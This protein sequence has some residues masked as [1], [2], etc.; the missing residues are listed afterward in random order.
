MDGTY[1]IPALRRGQPLREWDDIPARFAAGAAHLMV[2]GA[3]AAEAVER[4]IAG[5]TLGSDDV[6]AFGR[7]NFHCYLS[8]WVPMV[9]LYREPRIDPTAAELLAL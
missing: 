4:L 9:A 8:G 1:M 5:E 7:L 2:Q 3:E 6:I